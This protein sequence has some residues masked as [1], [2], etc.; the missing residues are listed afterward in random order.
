MFLAAQLPDTDVWVCELRTAKNGSVTIEKATNITLRKGYDNQPCFSA[1]AK[2]LYYSSVRDENQAD[3]YEYQLRKKKIRRVTSTPESEYS[4]C[5]VPGS[6]LLAT[7]VVEADSAQRIH[8]VSPLDGG[9]ITKPD[10]DSVGY[11]CYLNS[12]TVVYFKV[13]SPAQIRLFI[14]H[15]GSDQWIGDQPARGIKATN[16]TG[17]YYG[18]KETNRIV[19]YRYDLLRGKSLRYATAHESAEDIFYH[20]KFGLLSSHG[21]KI[22]RYDEAR[23]D[24]ADLFDL[25]RYGIKR[26]SRFVFDSE[27]KTLV[28]VSHND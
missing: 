18:L 15:S 16:R 21:T 6:T 23:E 7:V 19:Y 8:W 14:H 22:V 9:H 17:F 4:P 3:I 2:S 10:P 27:N 28:V 1:D 24:W 11:Y 25:S 13:G 20:A 26:I 5:P 12:D